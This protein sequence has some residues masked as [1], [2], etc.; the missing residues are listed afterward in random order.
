MSF[1]HRAPSVGWEPVPLPTKPPV[2]VWGWFKPSAAPLTVALQL[3]PELWQAG[4]PPEQLTLRLFAN[5]TGVDQ[6]IGWTLYGQSMPLSAETMK[7]LEAQL[8]PSQAGADTQLILWSLGAA[9]PT[10]K[11]ASGS[12]TAEFQTPLV[13][14]GGNPAAY[15]EVLDALWTNIGYLESDTRRARQQLDQS[16]SRINALD[17][18][19]TFEETYAADSADKQQWQ[20]AR[21]WLRD[22]S[23]SLT[24]TLRDIDV[25]L[26]NST[27]Q[28]SRFLTIYEQFIKPR[29]AFPGLEQAVVDFDAHLKSLKL[30]LQAVQAALHKGSSDGERRANTILQRVQQKARQKQ[31]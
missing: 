21:R 17:R 2:V 8:P 11:D 26:Q 27:Q 20:D 12:E 18:D 4:V 25:E 10:T 22:A 9:K 1:E 15:F 23:H 30:A 5:A 28:R 3:P 31:K 13:P 14:T 6:L 29:I 16:V 24:R 19:L 7:W